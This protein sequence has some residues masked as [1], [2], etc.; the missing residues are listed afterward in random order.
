MIGRLLGLVAPP[1]CTACDA[2][3]GR[4]APLCAACRTE[5]A[6]NA[7]KGRAATGGWVWSG[8]AYDGPAGALVR[9]L[10]FGGRTALADFMAAQI[11]AG[12]PP[13]MLDGALVP[14]PLHPA[15]LR[16]RGFNHAA[17]LA[18]A[19]GRRTGMP[20]VD[21]LARRGDPAPQMGRSRAA[22]IRAFAGAPVS[23]AASV[24]RRAVLVD[25]VVTTGATLAA[26]RRALAEAGAIEIVGMTYARTPGR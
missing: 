13:G 7:L 6:R 16:R 4:A 14:V 9:G 26:C 12:A 18:A 15:R 21:C 25:D 3:A 2:Y 20:V 10:K 17:L 11:V 8:F 1:L 19:L 22:R 23:A 24:P 5:L